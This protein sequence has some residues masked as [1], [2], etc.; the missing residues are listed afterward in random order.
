MDFREQG[1]KRIDIGEAISPYSGYELDPSI[2]CYAYVDPIPDTTSAVVSRAYYNMGRN[3]AASIAEIVPGFLDDYLSSTLEPDVLADDLAFVFFSSEGHR[4]WLLEESDSSLVLLHRFAFPQLAPLTLEPAEQ[5]RRVTAGLEW[6]DARHRAPA[7]NED[8]RI[9]SG[10]VKELIL[11][12]E[13]ADVS[14]SSYWLCRLL[15]ADAPLTSE[16]Q[17]DK[18]SRDADFWVRRAARARN[19]RQ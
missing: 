17:L 8:K 13:G 9:P 7:S 16:S 3:G 14:D 5:L 11:G 4:L 12:A 18:L 10:L 19:L 15:A 6:L 2:R 1:Y